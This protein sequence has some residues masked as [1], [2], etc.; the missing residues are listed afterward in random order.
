MNKQSTEEEIQWPKHFFKKV[1]PPCCI[2]KIKI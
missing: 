1:L 2:R